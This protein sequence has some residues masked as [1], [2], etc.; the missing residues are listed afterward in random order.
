[1]AVA[2]CA[3][4]GSSGAVYDAIRALSPD[5]F[6]VTGDLHYGNIDRNS[7]GLF[8]NV[9]GRSLRA[10]AQAALYRSTPVAYMW[11]DHD[12]GA[13][14][15]DASSP[16]RSAA[17][18]AYRED[19]PSYPLAAGDGDEAIYQAFTIGRVRFVLTD[20]R[21]ER[22]EDTMLGERQ[23]SWLEQEISRGQPY[24]RARRLGEPRPLDRTGRPRPQQLVR[25]T[26]KNGAAS[27]TPSP[28]PAPGSW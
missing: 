3:R 18:P 22:T 27:P 23:L 6:L 7:V 17:R 25:A 21:S 1:M 24:P 14:D 9:L 20:T 26:P 4:T 19:V 11:D 28:P 12:Y 10:P 5:L 13:N 8:R 15:A 16:S 2:S